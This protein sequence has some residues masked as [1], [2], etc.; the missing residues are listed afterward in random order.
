[1]EQALAGLEEN[2]PERVVSRLLAEVATFAGANR[3]CGRTRPDKPRRPSHV[4]D[5]NTERA[6]NLLAELATTLALVGRP[7]AARAAAAEALKI[8]DSPIVAL[9]AAQLYARIGPP[10][11]AQT[12]IDRVAQETPSTDT[13][14][15]AVEPTVGPSAPRVVGRPVREGDRAPAIR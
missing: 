1:M 11:T 14:V 15:N 10:A 12:L 8:S 9:A 4:R 3:L 2:S 5:S 7:E 6:G 13:L